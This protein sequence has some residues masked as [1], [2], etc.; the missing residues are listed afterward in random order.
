M[1]EYLTIP[2]LKR[3]T[4]FATPQTTRTLLSGGSIRW[5][6]WKLSRR[7]NVWLCSEQIDHGLTSIVSSTR[8]LLSMLPRFIH[9]PVRSVAWLVCLKFWLAVSIGTII[10]A[11]FEYDLLLDKCNHVPR[12]TRAACRCCSCKYCTHDQ[13]HFCKTSSKNDCLKGQMNDAEHCISRN[14]LEVRP[15]TN[16]PGREQAMECQKR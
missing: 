8:F 15:R 9:R 3:L 16:R 5:Q 6:A 1:M 12:F 4:K 2:R 14:P 7:P 13:S 11:V 10:V